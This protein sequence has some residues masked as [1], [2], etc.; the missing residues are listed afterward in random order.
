MTYEGLRIIIRRK[1]INMTA[2]KRRKKINNMDFT[3]ISNNCWGGFIYQSYGL[4]Y[5]SP[6]I[7]CFFMAEDYIKFISDIKKYM[8][9][10][11]EFIKA[12]ESH[13][14]EIIKKK[15]NFGLYPIG[16]LGDVE[17]HFLHYKSE[18]EA[19]EK[20]IT[21]AKRINYNKIL[22]KFNDQN[23]CTKELIEK[24][25][26]MNLKNKICFTS[27]N[28]ALDNVI[29]INS[30]KKYKEIKASYEPF[31][32]SKYININNLINNLVEE[33]NNI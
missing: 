23:G 26:K 14:F 4:K 20:W 2:K 12:T 6:T 16:R 27:K 15:P 24:F 33:N 30:S 11:L 3:I 9:L 22:Y 13:S 19:K 31:G 10:K 18:D 32:S 29:F 25:S 5:T 7:G 8:K 28:Y 1:Y 17:I 21:R